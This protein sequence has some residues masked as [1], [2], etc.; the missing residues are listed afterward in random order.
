MSTRRDR[1]IAVT[2]ALTVLVLAATVMYAVLSAERNGKKA[3]EGLQLA[4]LDQLARL[5]DGAVAPGLTTPVG[6]T[7]PTTNQPWS[8]QPGDSSDTAGLEQLQSRQLPDTRA[9]FALIDRNGTVVNGTLLTDPTSVGRAYDRPGLRRVLD[10]GKA[11]MLPVDDHSLTTPL[12]SVAMAR[13][14]T[15]T[16]GAGPTGAIIQEIDV[17]AESLFTKLMQGFRRANTDEYSFLD[18]NGIVVSSTAPGTV[19]KKAAA[20]MRDPKLGFH[21]QGDTVAAIADIPSAGWR[22][23]YRQSTKEFE[24]GVTGPLRTALLFLVGI[25][26]LGAGLTFFALLSRLRASRRE[27]ERLAAINETREEFISIVSHELRTPATGQLGF[28]QTLLDHWDGMDD[29]ERRKT[30]TQAYA[31]AR[32]LHALSRDV[33][34]TASVEA[35]QL[36]YAFEVI[37]LRQAVRDAVDAIDVAEREVSVSVGD[38][39]LLV[40]ADPERIQQ[41]LANLLDNAVKNSPAGSPIDLTASKTGERMALV[42]ISDRGPGITGDETER[43]FEKFSRGRHAGVRGT[44]LGLYICR[45][46]MD[47]H[48]GRIWASTRAGGG[49]TISFTLPTVAVNLTAPSDEPKIPV[50]PTA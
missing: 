34:D 28:L 48:G 42:E 15:A 29:G 16:P 47:A 37:D 17:A 1:V 14:I 7:N 39:A 13:P 35:G 18:P 11:A 27:Q 9:G 22:A 23:A 49:A 12:P 45:K 50:M 5:L 10:G 4:Q 43:S 33:L 31:N 3:L 2:A 19:G 46:I 25:A 32:R 24:G 26:L 36:P 8:L 21:R 30:V 40:R 6:L 38:E 20:I 44:G 41:V